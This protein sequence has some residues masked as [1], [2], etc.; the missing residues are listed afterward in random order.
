MLSALL[1]A[2]PASAFRATPLVRYAD[3]A[4]HTFASCDAVQHRL[5][6]YVNDELDVRDASERRV[7]ETMEL[8]LAGCSRCARRESQ[9][10][11]IRLAL[12]AVGA[13][14]SAADFGAPSFRSGVP[15][16]STDVMNRAVVSRRSALPD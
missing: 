7:R 1:P 10:H 2:L 4:D 3:R 6:E 15:Q 14:A 9:L 13:R 12:S 8:H 5:H 11:A 16:R